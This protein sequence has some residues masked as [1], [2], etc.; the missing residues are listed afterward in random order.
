MKMAKYKNEKFESLKSLFPHRVEN[1][2]EAKEYSTNFLGVAERGLRKVGRGIK[3]TANFYRKHPVDAVG[4]VAAA[5]ATAYTGSELSKALGDYNF[6]EFLSHGQVPQEGTVL[7]YYNPWNV[8]HH[9]PI[10]V[11]GEPITNNP[12]NVLGITLPFVI[13]LAVLGIEGA[14]YYG[15]KKSIEKVKKESKSW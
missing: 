15:W 7:P 11:P 2:S 3:E 6:R 5:A 14:R 1:L 9:G 10:I 12:M 4:T 13:P 8:I